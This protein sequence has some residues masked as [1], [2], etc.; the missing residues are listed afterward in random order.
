MWVVLLMVLNLWCYRKIDF[1]VLDFRVWRSSL[2]SSF[3]EKPRIVINPFL[4]SKS[5]SV[6]FWLLQVKLRRIGRWRV[7]F[8][9]KFPL[10]RVFFKLILD[11]VFGI[12]VCWI[13]V[14]GRGSLCGMELTRI[15]VPI[16]RNCVSF[17]LL[18]GGVFLG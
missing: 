17:R 2:C 3:T 15:V 8:I 4:K 12:G 11:L 18:I 13:L 16:F 9:K 6:I 10:Y 1:W 7:I 5:E 14:A